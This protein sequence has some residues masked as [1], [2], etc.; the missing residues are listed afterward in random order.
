M[1]VITPSRLTEFGLRHADAVSPLR[2]WA[3]VSEF[4]SGR[5]RLSLEQVRGLRAAL[6]IPADVLIE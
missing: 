5:R 3:R 2:Q 4:F 6:G 1:H